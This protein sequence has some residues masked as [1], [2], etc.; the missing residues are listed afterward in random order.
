MRLASLLPLAAAT[1]LC[2]CATPRHEITLVPVVETAMPAEAMLAACKSEARAALH[3][4][5]AAVKARLDTDHAKN[6]VGY[7]CAWRGFQAGR[8]DFG[9]SNTQ[10]Q[11]VPGPNGIASPRHEASLRIGDKLRIET[12]ARAYSGEALIACAEEHGYRAVRSCVE[13]C[14]S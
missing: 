14:P 3:R 11:C 12:A 10:A 1:L 7:D 6:T 4:A 8:S 9:A 5:R 2:A 13:G